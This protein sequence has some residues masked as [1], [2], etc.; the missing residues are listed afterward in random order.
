MS[1]SAKNALNPPPLPPPVLVNVIVSLLVSVVIAIP[2][3]ACNVNVSF[4]I[5]A[6][7]EDWFAI[8]VIAIFLQVSCVEPPD[9]ELVIKSVS[10]YVL[11]SSI[12]IPAPAFNFLNS[13]LFAFFVLLYE[14]SSQIF[15]F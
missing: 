14:V 3:P 1:A 12:V 11:P 7:R 4:I 8:P 9:P 10:V 5:S 15:L 13:K 6:V 2:A